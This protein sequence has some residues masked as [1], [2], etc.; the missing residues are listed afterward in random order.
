MGKN[1]K[2]ILKNVGDTIKKITNPVSKKKSY[3]SHIVD[4]NTPA[5][6][7]RR[8]AAYERIVALLHTQLLNHSEVGR[9]LIYSSVLELLSVTID[10]TKYIY[11]MSKT[12]KI[13]REKLDENNP[14]LRFLKLLR[15]TVKASYSL[16]KHE[17]IL[18]KNE[19]NL[20]EFLGE[21]L[22][23]PI[24]STDQI[25]SESEK[26]IYYA[27]VDIIT[28]ANKAITKYTK[29]RIKTFSKQ[30]KGKYN[31]AYIEFKRLYSTYGSVES[32]HLLQ[33][34][35]KTQVID[36]SMIKKETKE[37]MKAYFEK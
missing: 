37:H 32:E 34:S 28:V 31:K 1:N 30:D 27:I 14:M 36:L 20:S 9:I 16:V 7:A 23:M 22:S 25:F 8:E 12:K 17:I 35:L 18:S 10:A 13:S 11:P 5:L 33:E 2:I 4:M 6:V 21:E 24:K 19:K 3:S 26:N 29:A 15:D